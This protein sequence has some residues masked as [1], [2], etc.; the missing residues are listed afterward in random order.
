MNRRSRAREVA[1]QLLFQRDHNP[2]VDRADIGNIFQPVMGL[3][4]ATE[5]EEEVTPPP[6][7]PIPSKKKS[8]SHTVNRRVASTEPHPAIKAPDIVTTTNTVKPAIKA[9]TVK[10][11]GQP[12]FSASQPI[13]R[14]ESV[15]PRYPALSMSPAAVEL[16]RLPPRSSA[17]TPD[18]NE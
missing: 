6:S 9:S 11:A 14:P 4:M 12:W 17:S 10:T 1:L 7:S 18:R 16:P 13:G 2:T 3:G 8:A 5:H 15:A